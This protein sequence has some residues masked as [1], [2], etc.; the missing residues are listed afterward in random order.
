LRTLDDARGTSTRDAAPA[1][2]ELG[3][4]VGPVDGEGSEFDGACDP[5]DIANTESAPNAVNLRA[6][7]YPPNPRAAWLGI[8]AQTSFPTQGSG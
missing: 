4:S 7:M 1:L 3:G 2:F 5:Q 6:S 8:A